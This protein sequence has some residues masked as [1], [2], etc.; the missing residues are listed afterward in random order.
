MTNIIPFRSDPH[1]ATL[2]RLPWY[3]TGQLDPAERTEVDAHLATCP[4]CQEELALERELASQVARLSLDMDAGWDNLRH[5]LRPRVKSMA[6]LRQAIEKAA[7]W[8]G[9]IGWLLA[10]QAAIAIALVAIVLP[11]RPPAEYHLLGS[12]SRSTPGN[13]VIM[14]RPDT[15]DA[16]LRQTLAANGARIVDGPTTSG[17]YVLQVPIER[18]SAALSALQ[19]Q[20]N[21]VLAQ[22][23]DAVS[24]Q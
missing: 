10:A 21:V 12:A 23:I 14:F 13:V 18:R 20:P 19:A 16:E 7:A 24:G 3:V 8:P 5:R 6:G 22:P 9:R 1:R 17:A 4:D 11:M 15:T 2:E